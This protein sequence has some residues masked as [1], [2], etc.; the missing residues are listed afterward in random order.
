MSV[1]PEEL[2]I[3]TVAELIGRVRHVAVG[4]LSPIP[5]A[6]A[7]LGARRHDGMRVSIL[8]SR[9]HSFFTDGGRELFDCAGQGRIDAFFLS[10]GQIDG[11]GNVNLVAIGDYDRPKARFS[12]SFGSAYLYY[13]VPKVI[14]FRLEHTRRTLVD[15]VDFISAPG[16]SPPGTYRPGGPH[17]LVTELCVFQFDKPSGRFALASLHPGVSLDEVRDR[18][19]FAFATPDVVPTTALP[20][21][22]DLAL[23]RGPVA[24]DLAET[25]PAFAAE[26]LG[27]RAEETVR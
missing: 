23:M 16:T 22:A 15:R 9:R 5:A 18:T 13:V 21:D 19:G 10:G 2:L 8:N 12:G 1:R 27:W 3:G 14:L 7:L 25:Y 24:R 20:T 17:A 11:A 4:A 26:V 6:A